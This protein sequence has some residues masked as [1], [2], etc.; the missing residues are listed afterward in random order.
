MAN[1]AKNETEKKYLQGIY[2]F[3]PNESSPRYVKG[4]L[5]VNL[6]TLRNFLESEDSRDFTI[7]TKRGESF[8]ADLCE[9]KEGKLYLKFKE[10]K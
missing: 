5:V 8:I 1:K 3:E 10:S 4:V 2:F 9:S 7:E 6:E